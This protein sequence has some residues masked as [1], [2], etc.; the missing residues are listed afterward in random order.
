[1]L[2]LSLSL[3]DSESQN[4]EEIL[5]VLGG[6]TH[7]WEEGDSSAFR[8]Y[9]S[10]SAGLRVIEGG[11]QNV[12]VNDL[13]EHHVLPHHEEFAELDITSN[14]VEIHFVGEYDNAWAIKDFD[15][16]IK[17]KDGKE[18]KASGY[19]TCILQKLN[20]KWKIVHSHCSTRRMKAQ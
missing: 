15:V 13:I 1:M 10:S 8:R 5:M 9:F 19:E 17:T 14:N 12:G 11:E 18:T 2:F 4:K 16:R 7:A 6:V 3:H 20:G